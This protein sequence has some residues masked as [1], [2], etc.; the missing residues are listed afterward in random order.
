M[1]GVFWYPMSKISFFHSHCHQTP[2]ATSG[3][4]GKD[5]YSRGKHASDYFKTAFKP[6]VSSQA[7]RRLL[8][9]PDALKESS[10][11]LGP[12]E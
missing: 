7:T 12:E 5:H 2:D 1:R 8:Q 4:C 9:A 10:S 6:A 3:S 11:L